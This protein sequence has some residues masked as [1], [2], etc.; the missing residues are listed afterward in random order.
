[1]VRIPNKTS[2]TVIIEDT[3]DNTP[4]FTKSVYEVKLSEEAQQGD[5]VSL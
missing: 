1:V 2:V 3:N 4:K 5:I